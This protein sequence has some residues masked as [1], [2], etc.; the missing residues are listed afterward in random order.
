MNKKI[1]LTAVALMVAAT[2]VTPAMAIG[3]FQAAKT[4]DNPNLMLLGAA[5]NN[6]RGDGN[7]MGFNS[8]ILGTSGNWVEW[9]IRDAQYSK[10][11]MNTALVAHFA[12]V[13]PTFLGG[14]AN[15]NTWIYL[16]GDGGANADQY[17]FPLGNSL[18]ALGSHG[19]MW[20]MVF[21]VMG[22]NTQSKAIA[23]IMAVEFPAGAFYMYN[24]VT[25]VK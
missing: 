11:L 18:R 21:F 6:L 23:D 9:K 5:V 4:N 8:W 25:P 22:A 16:S 13:N 14:E 24:I 7:P 19:S 1:L 20:W 15:Q 12:N 10:G 17:I 3:P 2:L